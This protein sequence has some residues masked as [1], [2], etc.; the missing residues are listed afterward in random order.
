MDTFKIITELPLY[1]INKLGH[2]R[3]KYKNGNI[4]YLTPH[5]TKDNYFRVSIQNKHYLL[6]RLLATTFIDN[7]E[8][9]PH[10]DHLDRNRQNNSLEN[11]KWCTPY[12]NNQNKVYNNKG[13]VCETKHIYKNKTYTYY[14]CYWYE[15][16]K[17]RSK[18]FNT[19]EKAEQF[20]Q[21]IYLNKK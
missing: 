10:I 3:R 12:E 6:H 15:N 21:E 19:R 17:K 11:L 9:K 18:T 2:I 13:C 16:K 5:L 20:L 4:K 7:P 14:R 8:N 1:E